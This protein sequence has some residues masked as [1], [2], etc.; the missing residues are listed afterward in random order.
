MKRGSVEDAEDV[1]KIT[2]AHLRRATTLCARRLA[3]E[4]D[5]RRSMRLGTG[6]FRVQNRLLED[7][8]LTHV[9]LGPPDPAHFRAGDALT[10]E[11]QR[12]YETAA[13]WYV[14]LYRDRPVRSVDLGVDAPG[15]DAHHGD[16][17]ADAHEIDRGDDGDG[18][19]RSDDAPD[20]WATRVTALGVRLVGRCGLTVEDAAGTRE[21]RVLR[22]GRGVPAGAFLDDVD[23]RFAVLRLHDWAPDGLLVSVADLVHGAQRDAWIDIAAV[24]AELHTWLAERAALLATRA[25]AAAPEPGLDCGSCRFIPGC[26]AHS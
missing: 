8:R 4:R 10:A 18:H 17:V 15:A 3:R 20:L 24:S 12:L 21:L 26:K 6:R 16:E 1:P 23:V 13:R 11:E 9:D 2:A 7:A 5:D 22:L 19:V 25:A 14:A